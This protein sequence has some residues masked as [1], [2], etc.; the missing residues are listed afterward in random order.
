MDIRL[1]LIGGIWCGK[2]FKV[3]IIPE[4][5][6][7]LKQLGADVFKKKKKKSDTSK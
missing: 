2:G 7:I 6:K 5:A 3:S 4:N 1:D